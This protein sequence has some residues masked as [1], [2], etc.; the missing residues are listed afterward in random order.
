MLMQSAA[1]SM[2]ALGSSWTYERPESK[3]VGSEWLGSCE[4]T[5]YAL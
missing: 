2:E 5:G 1:G 3:S 4:I